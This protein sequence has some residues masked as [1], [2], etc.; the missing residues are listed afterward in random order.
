MP[1]TY[2]ACPTEIDAMRVR[3]KDSWRE[4]LAPEFERLYFSTLT[5]CVQVGY[6]P[7]AVKLPLRLSA[8]SASTGCSKHPA[9]NINYHRLCGKTGVMQPFLQPVISSLFY[10]N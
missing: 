10:I 4:T 3:L 7:L 2:S 5:D 9:N 1:F 8:T 6:L